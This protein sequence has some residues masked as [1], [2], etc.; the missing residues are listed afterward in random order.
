[1]HSRFIRQPDGW[2]DTLTLRVIPRLAGADPAADALEQRRA[3]VRTALE[4]LERA[5]TAL[6]ALAD[7]ATA[8]QRSAAQTE[9]DGAHGEHRSAVDALESVEQAERRRREVAEARRTAPPAAADTELRGG[10]AGG[11]RVE[12][13]RD[14]L[15]Y[16]R[17]GENSYLIDLAREKRGGDGEA[18]QRLTRHSREMRDEFDRREERA[19]RMAEE[20]LQEL[21]SELPPVLAR[22][23]E[24]EG[25][26]ELRASAEQRA[27]NRTD[28]TGGFFVPPLHL[29]DEYVPLARAGRPFVEQCRQIPL[30]GGTDSVNIPRIA[31]GTTT[32]IQTADN[33]AVSST[34][35]TDAL[36]TVPVRTIAGMQDMAMQVVD[37]SP[38]AFDEIVF[39]DLVADYYFRCEDQAING[40]NASGQVKGILGV[41]GVNAITYTD[42]TPT[43]PEIYPKIADGLRQARENRKR[44]ITHGWVAPRRYYKFTSELDASNRPLVAPQVQAPMNVLGIPGTQTGGGSGEDHPLNMQ[45]VDHWMTDAMPLTLGAGTNEDRIIETRN[46]DH[47]WM[48]GNLRARVLFEVLSGTLGVRFQ[49]YNYV[50]FTAERFP[51][52]TS[53]IAGTGL[54]T[55][56]F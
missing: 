11:G 16:R 15:T 35:L 5:S 28:G 6:D 44:P 24:A 36:I 49:V 46:S 23:I 1:M 2:L 14:P 52:A 27:L 7:D 17:Y 53:I 21:L 30:P 48:E 45:G 20:G 41:S 38:V 12:L 39:A 34:D 31:T 29:I 56:T 25:L 26:V 4:R 8:E 51:S 37:Q 13:Q 19:Q 3:A 47:I 32:A 22:R 10:G 18:V 33:A 43:L 55:P 54:V 9:F 40:T 42:A 50:A